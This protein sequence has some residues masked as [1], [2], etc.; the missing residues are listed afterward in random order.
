MQIDKKVIHIDDDD[1]TTKTKL[2]L[3]VNNFGIYV[4]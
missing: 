3:I 2:Y 1:G 4:F